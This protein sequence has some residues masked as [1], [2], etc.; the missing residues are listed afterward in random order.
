MKY[1]ELKQQ[2]THSHSNKRKLITIIIIIIIF[3]ELCKTTSQSPAAKLHL[4]KQL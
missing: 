1:T 2:H 3:I 4:G